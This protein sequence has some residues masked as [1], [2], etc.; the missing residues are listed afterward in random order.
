MERVSLHCYYA[1]LIVSFGVIMR[2]KALFTTI[3]I[4]VVILSI[5]LAISANAEDL[6]IDISAIGRQEVRDGLI[7]VRIGANLFTEDARRVNE[8]LEEQIRLR[9]AT[10]QYLFTSIP[11]IYEVEPHVQ[12]MNT[13]NSLALF[14]QPASFSNLSLPQEP[15]SIPMWIIL[16]VIALCAAGGFIWALISGKKK[17]G[18]A[19]GVH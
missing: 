17:K 18:Q 7:T 10:A 6:P 4:C 19:E 13:A 11:E 3:L 1:F 12:L 14:A 5:I 15:D 9:Q 8:A 2:K 16:A